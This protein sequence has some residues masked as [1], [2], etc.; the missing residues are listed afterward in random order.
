MKTQ[1]L[2]AVTSLIISTS[3][4][5]A[6]DTKV[7]KEDRQKMAEMH[8]SMASCLQSEKS[9]ND[10]RDEMM[11]SCNVMLDKS[12]CPMMGPDQKKVMMKGM[13]KTKAM[14]MGQE[15]TVKTEKK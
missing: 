1:M 12:A 9:L 10:C 5:Y 11:K 4:S 14:M 8:T 7:S 6:A 13:M 3:F 15:G 2:L